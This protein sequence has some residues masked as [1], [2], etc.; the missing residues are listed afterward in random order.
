MLRNARRIYRN[1]R[2]LCY[3]PAVMGITGLRA[4]LDGLFLSQPNTGSGQY[5]LHLWRALAEADDPP[6][7]TLLCPAVAP[8]GDTG[9]DVARVSVPRGLSS[10]KAQKLWWEQRGV[11]RAARFSWARTAELT[12]EVYREVLE[13]AGRR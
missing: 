2:A 1:V 3:N 5:T 6:R 12:R 13:G 4:G 9:G 7:T 10:A 11:L 8:D